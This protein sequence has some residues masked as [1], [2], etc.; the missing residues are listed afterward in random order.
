[1]PT[2]SPRIPRCPPEDWTDDHRE[3][4]AFW[5]EPN[6]WEEGSKTNI[7]STMANHPPLGKIYNKWGKYF[8]TE[9]T[10]TTRQ[11]EII[12]LRVSWLSKSEYEWHNHVGY[13][14]EHLRHT[15]KHHT[16]NI[17]FGNHLRKLVS[18]HVHDHQ[19]PCTRI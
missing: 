11:L 9:N 10:L 3:V 12:I 8:L 14:G 19:N 2:T 17:R 5:G 13:G 4:N 18:K 7:I 6:S 15:C 1:M 16:F